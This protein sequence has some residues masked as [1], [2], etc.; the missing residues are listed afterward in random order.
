MS[1]EGP[2]KVNSNCSAVSFPVT[3]VPLYIIPGKTPS[4]SVLQQNRE[5]TLGT[6]L[7]LCTNSPVLFEPLAQGGF[8]PTQR[9]Q[10]RPKLEGFVHTESKKPSSSFGFLPRS[11]LLHHLFLLQKPHGGVV[12]LTCQPFY[13]AFLLFVYLVYTHCS[14]ALTQI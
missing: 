7:T 5:S 3:E 1:R 11:L 2:W 9:R 10:K 14:V 4:V 12:R 8:S 6:E 13:L